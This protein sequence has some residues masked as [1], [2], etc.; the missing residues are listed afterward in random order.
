MVAVDGEKLLARPVKALSDFL[1]LDLVFG[2]EGFPVEGVPS[3][4]HSQTFR[5]RT[6]LLQDGFNAPLVV[7]VANRQPV[8]G[9]FG[10]KVP[11]HNVVRFH[12]NLVCRLSAGTWFRPKHLLSA[13]DADDGPDHK[14]GWFFPVLRHIY[15]PCANTRPICQRKGARVLSDALG[16]TAKF[17]NSATGLPLLNRITKPICANGLFMR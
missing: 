5:V 12:D 6:G 10:V 16:A 13:Q 8:L 9:A 4:N 2:Q 11:G 14:L 1:K 17:E 15:N 7:L 3:Q